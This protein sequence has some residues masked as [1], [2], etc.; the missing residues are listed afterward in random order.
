[1]HLIGRRLLSTKH[2]KYSSQKLCGENC[3]AFFMFCGIWRNYSGELCSNTVWPILIS[4]LWTINQTV[5]LLCQEWALFE[6]QIKHWL[7]CNLKTPKQ[8]YTHIIE[9]DDHGAVAHVRGLVIGLAA[10]GEGHPAGAGPDRHAQGITCRLGW[11]SG[12]TYDQTFP[13]KDDGLCVVLAPRPRGSPEQKHSQQH[14][15]V[16]AD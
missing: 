13:L 16:E 11:R 15:E 3:S 6:L 8:S 1:M 12:V 4:E 14:G 9:V 5:L 2:L 10:G 7:L